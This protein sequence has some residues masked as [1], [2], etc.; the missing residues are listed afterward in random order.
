VAVEIH[1]FFAL[2]GRLDDDA[3]SIDACDLIG[4]RWTS[5]LPDL[6]ARVV[7]RVHQGPDIVRPKATTEVPGCRRVRNRSGTERVQEDPVVAAKLDVVER[8]APAQH[9]VR[10][11]QDVIGLVVRPMDLQ[12]LD[13]GIDPLVQPDAVHQVVHRPDPANSNRARSLRHFVAHP[14]RRKLRAVFSLRHPALRAVQTPLN[15]QLLCSDLSKYRS[16]H[17]KGSSSC[18]VVGSK[19]TNTGPFR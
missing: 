2:A 13:V 8:P 12:Q 11:V 17:L 10:D 16:V 18:S 1:A 3:V 5:V 9:V 4:Q 15:F 6:D 7:D 19:P 14:P